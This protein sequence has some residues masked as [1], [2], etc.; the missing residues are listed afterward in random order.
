[1][2]GAARSFVD[3]WSGPGSWDRTPEARRAPIA[4]SVAHV[5]G[6]GDALFGEPAPLA[7]FSRLEIPVLLLV[8]T[9]S[10]ASSRGVARLLAPALP[11]VEL[12]ELEGLGHMGPVTHPEIVNR[13]IARFL[14]RVRAPRDA[15]RPRATG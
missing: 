8:G 2:D 5:G 4:A 6:W 1:V 11:R 3:H 15:D 10:P 7:A 13:A 12:V 14:E 9:E